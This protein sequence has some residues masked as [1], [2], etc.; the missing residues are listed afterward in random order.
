MDKRIVSFGLLALLA[1]QALQAQDII[2]TNDL[3]IIEA[4][5]LE[6]GE[7]R[8]FYTESPSS[9][10]AFVSI[11]K[12]DVLVLRRSDGTKMLFDDAAPQPQQASQSAAEPQIAPPL[13]VEEAEATRTPASQGV[14]P[15]QPSPAPVAS[16]TGFLLRPGSKVYVYV[17]SDNSC[18]AVV[19]RMIVECIEEQ[20]LW[21]LVSKPQQA[22][23][24]IGYQLNA[25]GQGKG[26][27][28]I[29]SMKADL[30][31]QTSGSLTQSRE[32][33]VVIGAERVDE[34]SVLA[35]SAFGRKYCAL[36]KTLMQDIQQG[37]KSELLTS[38]QEYLTF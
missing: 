31:T 5:R 8:L 29:E 4:H 21:T 13:V 9:D 2:V 18:E 23:F 27:M 37:N 17:N 24:Q 32:G 11:M 25:K 12:S 34:D 30:Q 36:L 6:I 14:K 22:Q 15:S 38:A 35:N 33:Y 28:A 3:R 20:G 16:T 19:Q 26:I 1:S 7:S 10:A